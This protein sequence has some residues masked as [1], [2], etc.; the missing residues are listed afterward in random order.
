MHCLGTGQ[1]S[2]RCCSKLHQGCPYVDSKEHATNLTINGL[3][4]LVPLV[5]PVCLTT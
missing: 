2:G 1:A 4:Y 3:R 5:R